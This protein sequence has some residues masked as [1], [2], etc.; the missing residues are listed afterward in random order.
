MKT[1]LLVPA[2]VLMAACQPARQQVSV[3]RPWVRLS[4]VPANPS[5]AYFTLK[6]GPKDETL[7]AVSAPAAMRAEMHESMGKGGMM[8]M[9]PLKLVA[10]RAGDS[11]TFAP[12]GKH[13]M[14]IGLKPDVKPRGTTPLTFTFASGK[15]ATV[16]AKVVGPGDGAPGE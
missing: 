16:Q 2:L 5:A 15:T 14:L 7:T 10:V 3:D 1:G 8:T 4:A 6:G 12:G 9:T 11:V 13:V